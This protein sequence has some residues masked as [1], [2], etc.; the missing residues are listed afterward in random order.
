MTAATARTAELVVVGA[1]PAGVGAAI[2]AARA[3]VEVVVVDEYLRAGGR[4]L[5]QLHEDPR[6]GEWVDG[7]K[8]AEALVAQ[9][10]EAGVEIRC[11]VRVWAVDPVDPVGP[12]DSRL[13]VRCDGG[14]IAELHA[15][16][17]VLATGAGE[18]PVPVPG[19]TL[20]G[21]MSIG[22]GQVMVNVHRVRPGRAAV[23]IGINVL[24]L[25]IVR[26]LSLA[27]VEVRAVVLPPPGRWS[28]GASPRSALDELTALSHLAPS[29]ILRM[30]G[31]IG[32]TGLGRWLA[33]HLYPK[34]GMSAF[35]VP[36]QARRAALEIVGDG[37]VEG[38]RI[39][40]LSAAGEVVGEPR[41]LDVDMACIAGG[42][43]PLA[44]LAGAAGCE[45]IDDEALGGEVPL[46]GPELQTT[47]PGLFVAGNVT[48]VEGA[49]VALAYGRLAGVCVAQHL[50]SPNHPGAVEAARERVHAERRD[51]PIAFHPGVS[52]ARER[53]ADAWAA[54]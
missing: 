43:Y 8:E 20:P 28:G 1:G 31:A 5:G 47:V 9:A 4:L 44:E 29:A 54:R 39:A 32:R 2:E 17:V 49:R 18:R 3:G 33:P 23:V 35:G 50:R 21:V 38:V 52:A 30:G 51:A 26:E 6:S 15:Q 46:H 22:A 48:G 7:M 40:D 24:S 14:G 34:R 45:L 11:G 37:R 36:V 10:L 42:L 13:V 53:V 12:G 41:V 16:A 19:W 25:A 27:G